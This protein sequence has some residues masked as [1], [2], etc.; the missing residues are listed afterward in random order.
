MANRIVSIAL[1]ILFIVG[2][3]CVKKKTAVPSPQELAVDINTVMAEAHSSLKALSRKIHTVYTN[4]ALYESGLY[5]D[6]EYEFFSNKVYYN[7]KP[8]SGCLIWVSQMGKGDYKKRHQVKLLENLED[9]LIKIKKENHL[10]SRV[11]FLTNDNILVAYPYFDAN[12]YL[13]PGLDLCRNLVDWAKKTD[14]NF[15]L[16]SFMWSMPYVDASGEGYVVTLS[17]KVFVN[18]KMMG[19]SGAD[20]SLKELYYE[21]FKDRDDLVFLL[22]KSSVLILATP[23][24][25]KLF[26]RSGLYKYDYLRG[27]EITPPLS[28]EMFLLNHPNEEIK[29]MVRQIFSRKDS[30][31]TISGVRYRVRVEDIPETDWKLVVLKSD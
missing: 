15:E 21:F 11:Y 17:L 30:Y 18:N 7:P 31:I 28:S 25:Q 6:R 9:D 1:I 24:V 5:P 13:V 22:E 12:I 19:S 14:R 29:L 8:D 3:G 27:A 26:K 4:S 10:I 23:G 16:N 20:I 2:P